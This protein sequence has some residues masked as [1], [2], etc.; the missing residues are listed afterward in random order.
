M[1]IQLQL[2]IYDFK[3]RFSTALNDELVRAATSRGRTSE[4]AS[5]QVAVF[6][7]SFRK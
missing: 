5:I 1:S 7:H 2:L 6:R 4:I 3:A